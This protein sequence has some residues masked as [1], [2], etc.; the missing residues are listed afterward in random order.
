MRQSSLSIAEQFRLCQNVTSNVTVVQLLQQ[1][2]QLAAINNQLHNM[3]KQLNDILYER[4]ENTEEQQREYLGKRVRLMPV[5]YQHLFLP[6]IVPSHLTSALIANC[7]ML[8]RLMRPTLASWVILKKRLLNL[9]GMCRLEID[10]LIVH[11]RL[12]AVVA[13]V[14][15]DRLQMTILFGCAMRV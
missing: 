9:S 6:Q 1:Q 7:P 4:L 2:Q 10:A 3:Q 8:L 14:H 15:N 11:F 12:P 5:R 13:G